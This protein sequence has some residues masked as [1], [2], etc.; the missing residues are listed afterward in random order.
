MHDARKPANLFTNRNFLLLWAAY[1]ISALG[2]HL[3]ELGLLKMQNA[4]EVDDTTRRQ[5]L[6]NFAFMAPFFFFGPFAGWLADVL[7]R[8]WVMF[9]VDIARAGIM[10][11]MLWLLT[12]LQKWWHPELSAADPIGIYVAITPLFLV[13]A[14]AAL[15]SPARLS[16]LPT[17]IRD[18]QFVSANALT[19]GV[20]MIA[21]I[22]SALLGGWLVD[23]VVAGNI[24]INTIFRLDAL[25][26]VASAA[27]IFF[28]MPPRNASPRRAQHGITAIA[29]GF[30]Y[31]NRHRRVLELLIMS[32]VFWAAAAGIKSIIPAIVKDVF[33]GSYGQIGIYQGL[34]GVGMILGAVALTI[35][36]ESL[37]SNIAVCWCLKLTGLSGLFMTLAIVFRLPEFFAMTGLLLIGFFGSGIQ[38]S[39]NALLQHAV[40]NYIRGRVFGVN[41]L[42][43]MFGFLLATGLLGIPDWPHIDRYVP[44]FMGGIS[45]GLMATGLIATIIRLRRGRFGTALTFWK[46]LNDFYA[47]FVTRARRK[48]LCTIPATGPAIIV[49]NHNSTFDPF[50]L[51]ST[52]PNRVIGFMIAKEFYKIPVF[53]W[54][55]Q[56]ID[57]IPVTRSGQD[58]ASVKAALRHLKDGK[59]L[60]IFPQGGIRDPEQPS[61]ARGGAG[62]LALRSGVPV[63][64]AYIHGLTYSE[65]VIAPFFWFSHRA[66]VIYG[67]PIDLSPWKGREKDREAARE[68]ADHIL[69]RIMALKPD[70]AEIARWRKNEASDDGA[71]VPSA[72]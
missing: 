36:G 14:F 8:K 72:E 16:L 34:M 32:A 64:P 20:G 53:K 35:L 65:K 63:I 70:D 46:N 67:E 43:S 58:T 24:E 31:V 33:G 39:I 45:A 38:V 69:A 41:D 52:T 9:G 55:C 49:A 15:F 21:T 57:C 40:P 17:L 50:V 10:L 37:R 23:L 71:L 42:L 25:T 66:T 3:S 59:L 54:L 6:M 51:T 13:G 68:V 19:A 62:L 26:F 18:E 56:S 2:D 28:I 29:K 60:G 4:L 48:G 44:A 27:L 47:R 5:A 11:G 30:S 12:S 61:E 7:P 22:A 1:G